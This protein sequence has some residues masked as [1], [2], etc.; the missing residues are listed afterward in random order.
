MKG[1]ATERERRK[2]RER[3]GEEQ[4]IQF[5]QELGPLPT[6]IEELFASVAS[7]TGS[8]EPQDSFER[9]PKHVVDYDECPSV[10]R[11]VMTQISTIAGEARSLKTQEVRDV[12]RD[13]CGHL[14]G[15]K[16][17]YQRMSDLLE[18][19]GEGRRAKRTLQRDIKEIW[20][21]ASTNPTD[22]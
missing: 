16:D 12:I 19:L 7:N 3:E 4:A 10:D 20:G 6:H 2:A 5:E 17:R 21:R 8:L 22:R 18:E 15:V 14:L 11:G 9:A 1:F 13:Y